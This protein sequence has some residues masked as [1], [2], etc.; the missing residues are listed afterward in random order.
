MEWSDYE[1]PKELDCV[2][3]I[4]IGEDA[5]V[6][7]NGRVFKKY[8]RDIKEKTFYSRT[9]SYI[10]LNYRDNGNSKNIKLHTCIASNFVKNPFGKS[11]VNHIDGDKSNNDSNNL[12]WVTRKENMIHAS[13]VGLT[14]IGNHKWRK[15]RN[16]SLTENEIIKS[17]SEEYKEKKLLEGNVFNQS[18]CKYFLTKYAK[19][20]KKCSN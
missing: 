2:E 17:R 6:Y 1:F 18:E 5:K 14:T 3:Y 4:Y 13:F 8:R 11:Q 7:K 10:V 16:V 19:E 15:H 9:K 20:L 12:E